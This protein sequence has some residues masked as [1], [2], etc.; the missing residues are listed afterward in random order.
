MAYTPHSCPLVRGMPMK[1]TKGCPVYFTNLIILF[2]QINFNNNYLDSLYIRTNILT[3][4]ANGIITRAIP[5]HEIHS[6]G[7]S[8]VTPRLAR[9]LSSG[10]HKN[11]NDTNAQ[12][13][14]LIFRRILLKGLLLNNVET[15]CFKLYAWNISKNS[16]VTKQSEIVVM[17]SNK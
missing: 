1:L 3:T 12:I 5:T 2:M 13:K 15:S 14:T 8:F 9:R 10:A 7:E 4:S 16:I 6:S 11:K 17:W